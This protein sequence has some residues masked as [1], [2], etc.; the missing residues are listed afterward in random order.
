M[1]NRIQ[2]VLQVTLVSYDFSEAFIVPLYR[3]AA[4]CSL[5]S[6][7]ERHHAI[8]LNAKAQWLRADINVSEAIRH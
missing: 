4:R 1:S 6:I 7:Q 5:R 3:L 8:D 2:R